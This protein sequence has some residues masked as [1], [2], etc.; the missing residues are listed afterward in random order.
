MSSL[1]AHPGATG[2]STQRTSS[3]RPIIRKIRWVRVLPRTPSCPRP[4]RTT[5]DKDG[6]APHTSECASAEGLAA[7]AGGSRGG[8][9][10]FPKRRFKSRP[11]A[12]GQ[13][14]SP[15]RQNFRTKLGKLSGRHGRYGWAP[16]GWSPQIQRPI[17]SKRR[18]MMGAIGP[19]WSAS[20]ANSG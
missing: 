5:A 9:A 14:F 10:T 15:T 12:A 13:A 8:T 16:E 11:T 1:V 7:V 3:A 19:G 4:P 18:P 17:H 6:R 2:T 20:V